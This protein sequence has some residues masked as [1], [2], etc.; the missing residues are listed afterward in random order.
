MDRLASWTGHAAGSID[1]G[2]WYRPEGHMAKSSFRERIPVITG[3]A[4]HPAAWVV[5]T[6]RNKSNNQFG[7]RFV[8]GFECELLANQESR[9]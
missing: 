6:V 4:T 8:N 3:A 5:A 2:D 1:Q 7:T 9:G